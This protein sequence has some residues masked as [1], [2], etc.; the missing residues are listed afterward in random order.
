MTGDSTANNARA[1]V[2]MSTKHNHRELLSNGRLRSEYYKPIPPNHFAPKPDDEVL[3]IG[4]V[5]AGIAGL[6]TASALLQSGHHVEV[7]SRS[8]ND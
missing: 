3:N 7:R 5:G 4:I 2:D 8:L 1:M 6:A